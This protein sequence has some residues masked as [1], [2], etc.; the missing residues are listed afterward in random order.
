MSG[1]ASNITSSTT[2]PEL[3]APRGADG[4]RSPRTVAGSALRQRSVPGI[5][6]VEPFVPAQMA[7]CHRPA[8]PTC[9][10]AVTHG[11]AMPFR[12]HPLPPLLA[13]ILL[14]SRPANVVAC[15]CVLIWRVP[16]RFTGSSSLVAKRRLVPTKATSRCILGF[17]EQRIRGS[18]E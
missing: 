15:V 13:A 2:S 18:H 6:L 11:I 8:V 10:G 9:D 5:L 12:R 1:R 17:E 3:R 4:H 7:L 16:D 14:Q